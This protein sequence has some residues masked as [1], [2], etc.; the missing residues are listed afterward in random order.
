MENTTLAVVPDASAAKGD[1]ALTVTSALPAEAISHVAVRLN[2]NV[3][4]EGDAL[5]TTLNLPTRQLPDGIVKLAASITYVS[6]VQS[7]VATSLTLSNSWTQTDSM[8]PPVNFLGMLIDASLTISASAGWVYATEDPAEIFW[9][10]GRRIRSENS[11]EELVWEANDL[12]SAVVTIYVKDL[13][14]I[15]A[16]R[17][18]VTGDEQRWSMLEMSPAVREQSP[19]GWLRVEVTAAVPSDTPTTHF[20]LQLLPGNFPPNELQIGAVTLKGWK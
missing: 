12:Q 19:A 15:D 8:N 1:M 20:R 3:I 18:S 16:L 2:E 4:W 5:P 14:A 11:L 6:G 10:Q 13:A 7:S 17:L 9:D